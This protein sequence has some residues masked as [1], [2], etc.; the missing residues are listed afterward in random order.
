MSFD[1][2]E[3]LERIDEV[4]A[5]GSFK[6]DWSSLVRHEVPSWFR[7]AKFGIFIHWGV[8]SVPAFGSEWYPRNMYDRSTKEF[9]HH[10]KVWGEHR[11]FGYKDF[12]ELFK[13]E[14]FDPAAWAALFAESGARYVV[15]VAE[16][17]DGFQMYA[18]DI[19]GWNSLEMGPKRNV[20]REL[21]EKFLELGLIPGA[22]SHRAEHWFFMEHCRDFDSGADP[23]DPRSLYHPAVRIDSTTA[24][25]ANPEP[26]REHMEDW[27]ARTCEIIDR[28]RPRLLY[29][30]WWI[31][32]KAFKPYL[33]KLMAYYYNRANEW[34]IEAVITYKHD[35]A[36]F[37][38]AVVDVE[39]GQF[40]DTM[41][42]PWQTC[43]SMGRLSWGYTEDNVF[44]DAEEIL[45]NLVDVVSKNGNLLLNIGPKADGTIT[46]EETENLLEIGAWLKKNGEAIY[47][48]RPWWYSS[49]GPTKVPG[50]FFT[51]KRKI[52]Y[53]TADVRYT[54]AEG[55]IY[56]IAMKRSRDGRY[57]FERLRRNPPEKCEGF[58]GLVDKV[59]CLETGQECRFEIDD[60]GLHLQTDAPFDD[61]P[62]AFRISVL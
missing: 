53:T 7:D 44:K 20:L 30:D 14:R 17:H 9:E 34:G 39:R 43:T 46:E 13:A 40:E 61:T 25:D 8:Y 38:S 33:R 21:T 60:E 50:G 22:S 59:V 36:A 48:S 4:I 56:A 6:D 15:P 12:I 31:E 16:H 58:L 52:E 57:S 24:L 2:K 5:K 35:A 41:H 28:Y 32:Q 29:F 26:G 37:G 55:N 23:D 62:I 54:T 3:Y 51:D 47:G 42:F 27:L 19:S 11:D 45:Q 18:S 10:R 49:E 1:R